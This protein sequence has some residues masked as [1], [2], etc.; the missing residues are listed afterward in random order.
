MACMMLS[1]VCIDRPY[2]WL[3]SGSDT[4]AFYDFIDTLQSNEDARTE[5]VY[6][7]IHLHMQ[8]LVHLSHRHF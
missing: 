8:D 2:N 4:Y 6:F 1:G 3:V 7:F 5:E